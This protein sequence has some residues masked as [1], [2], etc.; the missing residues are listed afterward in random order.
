M[1]EDYN[2]KCIEDNN[3]ERLRVILPGQGWVEL[4]GIF[5]LDDLKELID[6]IGSRY[7]K[8]IPIEF[9]P[10]QELLSNKIEAAEVLPILN[11]FPLP[12]NL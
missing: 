1:L 11:I 7:K 12:N 4:H 5:T 8:V 3:K 6:K 2:E 10:G 9:E